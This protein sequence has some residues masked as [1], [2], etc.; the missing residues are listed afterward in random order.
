MTVDD[1]KKK[2]VP[3]LK[4]NGVAR[5]G[6]FGSSARGEMTQDSDIDLLVDLQKKASLFEFVALK[7][8]LEDMLGRK[9]DLV[10][11]DAIKPVLKESILKHH[12]QLI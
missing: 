5:A 7:Q 9:V 6:L 3:L 11:Y 1:L 4:A 8:E 12:V 2:I 10:T